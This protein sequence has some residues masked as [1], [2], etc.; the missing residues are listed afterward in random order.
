VAEEKKDRRPLREAVAAR[1]DGLDIIAEMEREARE[2]RPA[3]RPADTFGGIL[4]SM[5]PLLILPQ[6]LPLFQQSLGQTLSS[7]TVNVRVESATALIPIS[8]EAA[9]AIV[10]IEIRAS[11]V[12]L[13]VA[14]TQSDVTLKISIENSTV[15]LD[16]NITNNILNINIVGSQATLDINI[17]SS[18]TTLNVNITNTVINTNITNTV[19]NVNANITNTVLN[20]NATIVNS[21]VTL[22]VNVTNSSLNI[23]ITNSL[24]NLSV[25]N[26]AGIPLY[27]GR[28]VK[29]TP[30]R[31]SAS[32]S[33][34]ST[35]TFRTV[36]GRSRFIGLVADIT[37]TSPTSSYWNNQIIIEVDGN[38]SVFTFRDIALLNGGI[39]PTSTGAES[40]P[41]VISNIGGWVFYS[42]TSTADY[43]RLLLQ[44][45]T[46]ATTSLAIRASVP[47]NGQA[48]SITIISLVGFYP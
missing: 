41:S 18:A 21:I 35:V 33:V 26:P 2:E 44:F 25:V 9:T 28:P 16:V 29:I 4:Q 17:V 40:R 37:V 34:G 30:S 19:L 36:S 24:V 31:Y 12:T 14:I 45:E 32:V 39:P 27:S 23:V 11:Q 7:T 5:V 8:V 22:N 1:T 47:S 42:P 3:G 43:L 15:T 46:D 38:A 48:M 20:V 13:N 10:P 6:I